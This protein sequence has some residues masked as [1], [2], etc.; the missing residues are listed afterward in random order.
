MCVNV[1]ENAGRGCMQKFGGGVGGGNEGSFC[2]M[3]VEEW[4]GVSLGRTFLSQ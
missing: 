1:D 4:M 3:C 2:T